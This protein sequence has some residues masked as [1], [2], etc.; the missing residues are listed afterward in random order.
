[1]KGNEKLTIW[2]G[3]KKGAFALRSSGSRGGAFAME[4]PHLLGQ[5]VYH[6]IQDPRNPESLLMATKTG[7]LGP[8]VMRSSDGGKAWTEAAKPPQFEK[9]PEGEK[10]LAVARVFWLE[11]GH[12]SQPG[13]WWAGIDIKGPPN[14]GGAQGVPCNVALF[15]SRDAGVNWEEAPGLRNYLTALPDAQEKLGFPPG[16]AMLHSIR[17]DPRD[18]KHLYISISS[19]GTFESRD[20]G[21]TWKPLNKG[22]AATFYPDVPLEYGHD[23]HLL[24][25]HPANP[26]RLYQQNHCGMYRLDRGGDDTWVRIG[27]NMPRSVGDIGF[28]IVAH[29]RDADT[30]WVFPMDGGTVWPRTSPDGKPAVYRTRDAGKTWERQDRGLPRDFAFWTVYRQ[31]MTADTQDPVGLYFGTTSGE[32][33][34]SESEGADWRV[35]AQHLP[36]VM[37][38]TLAR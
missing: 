9:A 15:R 14:P 11:P 23:P 20:E 38:V 18:A 8:T 6:V 30:V 34:A 25:I 31:A 24:V 36:Q 35:L 4:G 29:P 12:A 1:M 10:G 21:A 26:D 32:I 13:T 7:H 5:E 28:P 17:V 3:T 33:W 2:I 37:S 22:V 16:G 19:A 27:D